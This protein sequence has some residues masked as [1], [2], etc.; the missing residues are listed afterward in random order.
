VKNGKF[1]K[2]LVA[3]IMASG[4]LILTVCLEETVISVIE[5]FIS[6]T[7]QSSIKT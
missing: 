4:S 1:R 6:S 7:S 5:K 3:A 2:I